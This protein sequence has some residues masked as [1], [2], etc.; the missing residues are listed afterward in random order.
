[1]T[2][3]TEEGLQEKEAANP[4]EVKKVE[5]P[6][7]KEVPVS[8]QRRQSEMEEKEKE[9][10]EEKVARKPSLAHI[11]EKKSKDYY[12]YKLVGVIM[13]NGNAEAGHYYSYINVMRHEWEQNENYL[14]TGKDR[15]VEFND[16]TITEFD[17]SKLE[18]ECFGGTQEDFQ[19][20]YVE[21]SSEVA[22]LIGGRSKSGYML[23]YERRQKSP[24]PEKIEN[25]QPKEDDI[26]LSSLECDSTAESRAKY[27]KDKNNDYYQ[28]HKYHQVPGT[29]P[30][31]ISEV[32][33]NP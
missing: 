17:F 11:K 26:V 1:M 9:Q 13:H 32:I 19:T 16:S 29:I 4:K 10:K 30:P 33:N 15:W 14:N 31:T 25:F 21:D 3:Y 2:P 23:V 6:I 20:G 8:L 24:I 5:E 27:F 22:K 7:D 28:L 18:S 12:T